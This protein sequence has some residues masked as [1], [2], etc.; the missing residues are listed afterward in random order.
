MGSLLL[1]LLIVSHPV[2]K[3]HSYDGTRRFVAPFTRP[4]LYPTLETDEPLSFLAFYF[5]NM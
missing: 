5:F 1:E 3:F 2:K 4:S